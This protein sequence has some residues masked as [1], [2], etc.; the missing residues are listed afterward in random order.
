MRRMKQ[1]HSIFLIIVTA[2]IY[3]CTTVESGVVATEP[4][5]A[6]QHT[7]VSGTGSPP[8]EALS[9]SVPD[10]PGTVSGKQHAGSWTIEYEVSGGFAGIRRQLILSG[11]GR[12]IASDLKS[13][14]CVEKQAPPEQLVKIADALSKVDFSRLSAT[15]PKF[16]NHCADCFQHTL[17]M[18]NVDQ[19]YKPYLDDATLKDPA[20]TELIGLLS[21]L[22]NQ[23]LIKQEP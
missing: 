9:P 20:W 14:R 22:L 1:R 13:K 12:I 21:S 7:A 5:S 16:S 19:F 17:T 3:A 6:A 11:N 4:R 2:G 23:A 18:I 10:E 8:Q 15:G